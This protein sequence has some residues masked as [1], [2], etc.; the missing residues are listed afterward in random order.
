MDTQA[1]REGYMDTQAGRCTK[2][3]NIVLHSNM[4]FHDFILCVTSPSIRALKMK[5]RIQC[6]SALHLFPCIH[7]LLTHTSEI[8]PRSTAMQSLYSDGH[9]PQL[10]ASHLEDPGTE[11]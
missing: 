5:H 11:A 7:A 2:P 9:A 6:C 10:P 4:E 1:G 3:A 8:Q